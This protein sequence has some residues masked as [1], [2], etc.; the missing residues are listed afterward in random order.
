MN[1]QKDG[2]PRRK[3]TV[4]DEQTKR[5]HGGNDNIDNVIQMNMI[6]N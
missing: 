5:R 6:M 1:N 4:P 2:K 3:L